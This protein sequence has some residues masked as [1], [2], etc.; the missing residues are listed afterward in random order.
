MNMLASN[1]CEYC[2]N[3]SHPTPILPMIILGITVL[4]FLTGQVLMI[5]SAISDRKSSKLGTIGLCL[6][7]FSIIAFIAIKLLGILPTQ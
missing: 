6:L 1:F 3:L 7:V 2:Y 4:S 5:I